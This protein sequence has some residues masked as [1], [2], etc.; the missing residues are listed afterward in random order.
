MHQYLPHLLT[1]ID[2]AHRAEIRLEDQRPQTFEEHIAEVEDWLEGKEP[3]HSFGYYCGL[4][5][6]NFPPPEQ[7]N[8]A[9]IKRVLKAFNQMMFSWNLDIS[10]PEL[11]PLPIAYKMTVDT[12][13]EKTSIVNSGR[14]SF[15]FCTGYAP[16]CV[17]KEYCPCLKIWNEADN[18]TDVD[19]PENE[20]PF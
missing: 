5:A 9:E 13:N 4:D 16:D 6:I 11:L 10:L 17:F 15:D 20:W 19:F 12:L 7:F 14:M 3:L 18:I 1:D 8:D 2:A